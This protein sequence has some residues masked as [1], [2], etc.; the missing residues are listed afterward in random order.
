MLLALNAS[1]S[2]TWKEMELKVTA[3]RF[4]VSHCPPPS[5][6]TTLQASELANHLEKPMTELRGRLIA[7]PV[8]P[9]FPHH[10]RAPR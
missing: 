10:P 4:N 6:L 5:V 7:S 9:V 1:S 8:I 3:I 2:V